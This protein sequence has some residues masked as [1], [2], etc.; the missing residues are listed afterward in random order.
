M[1]D[2][3][4]DL[5]DYLKNVNIERD[6]SNIDMFSTISIADGFHISRSLASQY[7]NSLYRD[8]LLKLIIDLFITL[9]DLFL[10]EILMCCLIHCVFLA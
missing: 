5:L 9:I 1:N 3:K 4:Q 6:L 2:T 10:K 8:N 7:L